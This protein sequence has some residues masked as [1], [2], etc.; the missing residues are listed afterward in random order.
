MASNSTYKTVMCKN[1]NGCCPFGNKC[2]FAHT[3]RELRSN[4]QA[5]PSCDYPSD[6]DIELF[7]IQCDKEEEEKNEIMREGVKFIESMEPSYADHHES[8]SFLDAIT[9]DE[10]HKAVSI[11]GA[12]GGFVL[13]GFMNGT[14]AQNLID[15]LKGMFMGFNDSIEVYLA[16]K[17]GIF[18]LNVPR[19]PEWKEVTNFMISSSKQL[20]QMRMPNGDQ[21]PAVFYHRKTDKSASSHSITRLQVAQ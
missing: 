13:F 3:E 12:L 16:E 18:Y 11:V 9:K 19:G 7:E 6:R 2:N 10:M 4:K 8:K 15:M 5:P 21:F 14:E 1:A 20:S 17:K